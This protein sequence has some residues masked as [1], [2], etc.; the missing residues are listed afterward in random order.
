MKEDEDNLYPRY[1]KHGQAIY[2]QFCSGCIEERRTEQQKLYDK[3]WNKRRNFNFHK[4]FNDTYDYYFTDPSSLSPKKLDIREDDKFIK[5]KKSN[6]QE[7]LKKNYYK[8]AKKFH[9]DKEGGDTKLFQ[10][11][12]QLYDLL[13]L[14]IPL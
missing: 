14:S 1:C 6:S 8:L 4:Y 5:L 11:L 10:K 12:S 2:N 9:P 7:E 13:K 3:Y